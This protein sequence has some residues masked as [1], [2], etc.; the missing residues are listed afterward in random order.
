MDL[1]EIP[2]KKNP[3]YILAVIRTLPEK[4][5]TVLLQKNYLNYTN[6]QIAEYHGLKTKAAVTKIIQ[7]AT[8]NVL[9]KLKWQE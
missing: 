4:E 9:K 1:T 2:L 8:K 7:R 3:D 5:A 6:I